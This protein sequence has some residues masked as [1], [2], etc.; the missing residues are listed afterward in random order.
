MTNI[1]TIFAYHPYQL[2]KEL[3]RRVAENKNKEHFV[4]ASCVEVY[5]DELTD[6]LNPHSGNMVIREH[7]Q[8]GM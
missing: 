6:M 2:I 1:S 5:E 8:L 3:F 4:T 7:P